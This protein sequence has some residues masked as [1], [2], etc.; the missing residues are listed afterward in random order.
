MCHCEF[1]STLLSVTTFNYITGNVLVDRSAKLVPVP[2]TK[3]HSLCTYILIFE[4]ME[5]LKC[6]VSSDDAPTSQVF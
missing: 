1:S 6:C 4:E 3:K 5:S 2:G